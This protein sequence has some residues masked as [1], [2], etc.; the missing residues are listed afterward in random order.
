MNDTL[1]VGTCKD[2]PVNFAFSSAMTF[3][4]AFVAPVEAGMMSWAATQIS[5]YSFRV[6]PFMVFCMT[7][8]TWTV[9]HD[10]KVVW[11]TLVRGAKQLVQEALLTIFQGVVILLMV[12]IPHKH[13][14]IGKRGGDDDHLGPTIQRS[15]SLLHGGKDPTGLYNILSTNITPFDVGEILLLEDGHGL[16][17]DDKFPILSF[18]YAIEFSMG[19]IILEYVD[20][21]VEVNEGVIDGDNI[22]FARVKS[23]IQSNLFTLTFTMV[24][25]VHG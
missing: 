15:P 20:H 22:H 24:S 11:M 10:A 21:V 2:M 19:G 17:I 23:P 9:D 3:P 6:G 13:G 14:G 16:S 7:V 12:P 4:A 8:K 25:R 1:G 18:E 5:C